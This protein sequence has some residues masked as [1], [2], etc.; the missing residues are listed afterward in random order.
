VAVTNQDEHIEQ[1]QEREDQQYRCHRFLLRVIRDLHRSG[2]LLP[3]KASPRRAAKRL[4]ERVDSAARPAAR[5]YDEVY[6]HL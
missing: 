2:R 1:E 4:V 3:G 6:L 5:R